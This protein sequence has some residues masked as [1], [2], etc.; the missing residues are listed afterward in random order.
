MSHFTVLV[1]L[2]AETTATDFEERLEAVLAPYDEQLAVET[3]VDE[4]GDT[5][6]HNPQGHWDWWTIGGR[7]TGYF[8]PK[9]FIHPDNLVVGSPGL[10]TDP[11]E[12]GRCDGGRK[13]DL[14]LAGMRDAAQTKA[15][16]EWD[17]YQEII[18]GTPEPVLWETFVERVTEAENTAAIAVGTRRD[19]MH[20]AYREAAEELG[21]TLSPSDWPVESTPKALYDAWRQR[22]SEIWKG[23]EAEWSAANPYPIDQA[24][25]DYAAQERVQACR[26]AEAYRGSF[27]YDPI[28]EIGPYTRE[29]YVARAR[30]AAVSGF[31]TILLDGTWVAPGEMGW[32]GMSS[33]NH[34]TQDAYR[35]RIDTYID[36]EL[37]ED[38][39]LVVVDCHV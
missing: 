27:F 30:A 28:D 33:D 19:L 4:D 20:R 32:F 36:N 26:N 16:A 39:W 1:T 21:V 12:P 35:E 8:T 11:A 23:Y 29:Q 15:E 18:A 10:M 13:R 24:R 9:G 34:S 22:E 3:A 2:P 7:W 37:P 31:A 25:A 17:E 14:D 38:A 5:Y 6:Q